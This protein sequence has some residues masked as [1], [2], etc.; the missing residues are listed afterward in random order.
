MFMQ[1][2]GISLLGVLTVLEA[3]AAASPVL[4]GNK[5]Y[6]H[7]EARLDD[8]V[9]R[10]DARFEKGEWG[11]AI[12]LYLD[13]YELVHLPDLL[14][15][16]ATCYRNMGQ[17]EKAEQNYRLFLSLTEEG[18]VD[19]DELVE[20]FLAETSAPVGAVDEESWSLEVEPLGRGPA[21][22]EIDFVG[23]LSDREWG[24]GHT[25]GPALGL[26]V[27]VLDPVMLRVMAGYGREVEDPGRD[28][29]VSEL[30]AG[31]MLPRLLE[32]RIRLHAGAATQV[33]CAWQRGA[34][35]VWSFAIAAA[36]GGWFSL[37]G[38]YGLVV[39]AGAGP[40]FLVGEAGRAFGIEILIKAGLTFDL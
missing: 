10:G 35:E 13:A 40:V 21:A 9:A 36:L 39:E 24:P 22:L 34:R 12:G 1:M 18:E 26:T 33:G 7:F 29:L 25:L 6:S 23:C 19:A 20:A 4:A 2:A 15:K 28:A 16:V 32:G 30:L 31:V 11:Q 27:L 17:L 3:M 37:R 14:L 8:L 38:R 5:P